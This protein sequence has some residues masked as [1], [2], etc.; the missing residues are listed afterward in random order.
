[1]KGTHSAY[2]TLT[3]EEFLILGGF[4]NLP[5]CGFPIGTP[6]VCFNSEGKV[7]ELRYMRTNLG[8]SPTL[9]GT[10]PDVLK[11]LTLLNKES[12]I[13]ASKIYDLRSVTAFPKENKP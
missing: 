13:A 3:R 4:L 8:I 1:M 5:V 6:Y 9:D 11:A 10:L 2:L 7:K 12:Y